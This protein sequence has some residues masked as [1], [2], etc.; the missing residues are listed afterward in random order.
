[1]PAR[2]NLIFSESHNLRKNKII[3]MQYGAVPIEYHR[4]PDGAPARLTPY[5]AQRGAPLPGTIFGNFLEHLGFSI[6]GGLWAQELSNPTFHRDANLLQSHVDELLQAGAALS[7]YFASGNDPHA[8]PPNWTPWDDPTGF[9]VMALDDARH[10]GIPFPWALLDETKQVKASVGRLGGAVRLFAGAGIRQGLFLP[11]QR[12]REYQGDVWVRLAAHEVGEQ[13]TI[14]IGV[15]RRMAQNGRAAGERIAFT[16]VKITGG[17]WGKL[18]YRLLLPEGAVQPGEPVDV[19]LRWLPEAGSDVHLLVDRFF[20]FPADSAGVFDPTIVELVRDWPVPLLRWPGGNFASYYHWRDGVGPLDR[21]PTRKN[22]TWY[23]LEYNAIGTDEF[24]RFC[25]LIG[26]QPHITVN[27]GTGTAEEAAAWVQY[28][29]GDASTPMGKLRAANGSPEPYAVKWWE[30]GNE[31]YGAWQGGYFGAEE[32][33]MRCAEFAQAMRAVDPTIALI[34]TGS[35]FDFVQPGPAFDH[36]TADLQWHAA[37]LERVSGKVNAISLHCLPSNYQFLED[38][39]L[40]EVHYALMAQISTWERHFLPNLLQL[41]DEFQARQ[42]ESQNEE[43]MQLAITEWAILGKRGNRPWADTY[44]EVIYAGLFLNMMARNAQRIPLANATGLLHG[45]SIRKVAGQY[46]TDPQ[47][48]AIQLY[49]RLTGAE[50]MA[51]RLEAP[52]YDVMVGTDLGAPE[53]DVPYVD[54]LMAWKPG[55]RSGLYL[56]VVNQH[57]TQT[58]V[59]HVSMPALSSAD[60]GQMTTISHPDG[61]ARATL[62]NR[63]PYQKVETSIIVTDRKVVLRLPPGSVSL[64]WFPEERSV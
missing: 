30:I 9:G 63:Q 12:V 33:A 6:A 57:L 32:N 13:G 52:G 54:A 7:E 11:V 50:P 14:E 15:Q 31:I 39:S 51:C 46:F 20:L 38:A 22:D 26:A 53:P 64:A 59:L 27:I 56:A 43:P 10:L 34:A 37:L 47:Y 62:A 35:S 45:G 41:A 21:R 18:P 25:R 23:G 61:T 49:S 48:A 28:C 2:L 16:G 8:L 19:Y 1:M 17:G 40:D 44:G 36:S 29:N 5:P 3:M 60:W 42:G 55:E 4:L 58:M 24:I